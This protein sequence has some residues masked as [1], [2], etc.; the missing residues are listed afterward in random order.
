M[1]LKG[2]LTD[3]SLAELI[4][5]FCNQRKTGRLTV[6]YPQGPAYFY[7]QSGSVVHASIGSLRGIEAVYYALTQSNAS[8]NFSTAYEA[9]AQ[10]INQPWTSVVLEG[11]RRMDE[12]IKPRNPFPEKADAAN[13][14]SVVNKTEPPVVVEPTVI[15]PS[16]VSPPL[17]TQ[18][19]AVPTQSVNGQRQVTTSPVIAPPPQSFVHE[20]KPLEVKSH[21]SELQFKSESAQPK[22][23]VKVDEDNQPTLSKSP[24]PKVNDA[25]L[26]SSQQA[27]RFSHTPWKLAAI[28]ASLVL[29]VAAVAVPWGWRARGKT[30]KP[31]EP[32]AAANESSAQ[33]SQPVPD[34][35]SASAP[36][37]A[38]TA[39]VQSA[40]ST[41]SS[42]ESDAA[43][44]ARRARE[45]H[46]REEAR[47]KATAAENPPTTTAQSAPATPPSSTTSG[48]KKVVVQ[49]TYDENG[50]VTQASGNDPTA[51][52]IA[53]QK[54]F[55]P[56]KAGSTTI[57]IPIN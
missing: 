24:M 36:A 16:I 47:L 48:P 28:F 54:R 44:A 39:D 31:A 30:T 45:A 52:R 3:L 50:R 14:P 42:A 4:E 46:A 15:A 57:T 9:P 17:A 43:T 41:G 26:S 25:F 6:L 29:L 32:V 35:E 1:S 38:D 27:S 56:G 55:P 7:L 23:K 49:V 34:S 5:F 22:E 33:A 37:P 13:Q 51:L 20:Q 11:L 19:P 10:T 2:E 53:R 12:E 18:A 40:D 21:H 8:F